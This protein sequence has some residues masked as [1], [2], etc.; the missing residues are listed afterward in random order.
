MKLVW[1]L[2]VMMLAVLFGGTASANEMPFSVRVMQATEQRSETTGYFDLVLAP[3][4]VS[5]V[6]Y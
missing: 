1:G 2:V 5:E 3:D 6:S 4:Q